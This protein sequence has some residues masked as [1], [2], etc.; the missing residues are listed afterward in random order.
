[1]PNFNST[2]HEEEGFSNE[3]AVNEN[4]D[5]SW[6]SELN[7]TNTDLE[8]DIWNSTGYVGSN[9][10][11]ALSVNLGEGATLKG[12]ISNGAFSHVVK[13]AKVN[14]GDWSEASALGHVVNIPAVSG[15]NSVVVNLTDD[16]VWTVTAD[17]LID[18]LNI[19]GDAQVIIPE[20]ITL[21]FTSGDTC[22]N[23][24]LTVDGPVDLEEAAD[25]A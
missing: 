22:T 10:G 16:A 8:G 12:L 18:E 19:S 13:D 11:T 9:P 15:R 21:T 3:F 23:T 17:C 25:A 2:F 14:Y 4:T 7:V 5:E 6:T 20:G 24:I 1:M